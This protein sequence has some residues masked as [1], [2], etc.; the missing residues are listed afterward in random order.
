MR[1]A[2]PARARTKSGDFILVRCEEDRKLASRCVSGEIAAQRELFE[3]ERRRVHATLFRLLGTNVD[4]DDLVQ[5]AFFEIFRSLRSFR[6]EASLRTWV[7]RCTTRVA[8][9]YFS[10]RS[11]S[12]GIGVAAET[13]SL[14]PSTENQ[15]AAREATR[16]LYAELARLE[17]KQRLAFVLHAIEG[18]PVSEVASMMESSLVA[19]KSRI[20][21]ARRTIESRARKDS[22]LADFLMTGP[23][24][25]EDG[26]T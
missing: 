4:I 6:G 2:G 24:S 15:V 9:A 8:Y 7:D 16:R 10:R 19:T 17:P 13:P 21:R 14:Q 12:P 1:V 3:R 20:W 23:A 11:R 26:A 25:D 22:V 18:R 5:D